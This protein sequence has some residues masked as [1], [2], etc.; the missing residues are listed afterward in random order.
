MRIGRNIDCVP[1]ATHIALCYIIVA[2]E[3]DVD[4]VLI[5]R[6]RDFIHPCTYI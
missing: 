5:A 1:T 3:C 2:G 6:P 4:D